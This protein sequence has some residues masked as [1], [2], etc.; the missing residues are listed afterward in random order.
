MRS[1]NPYTHSSRRTS[2]WIPTIVALMGTFLSAISAAC[3]A[4]FNNPMQQGTSIINTPRVLIFACPTSDAFVFVNGYAFA[5]F[6]SSLLCLCKKYRWYDL[7]LPVLKGI[8]IDLSQKR[9][10]RQ[11]GNE[12]EEIPEMGTGDGLGNYSAKRLPPGLPR[13]RV[14]RGCSHLH[15]GRFRAAAWDDRF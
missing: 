13:R 12:W 4:K 5:H 2:P 11:M 1:V 14:H 3:L 8:Y 10:C 6:G 15:I 7:L 9:E